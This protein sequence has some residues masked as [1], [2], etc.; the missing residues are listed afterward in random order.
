MNVGP[1][2]VNVLA[3]NELL[4]ERMLQNYSACLCSGPVL[5]ETM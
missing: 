1:L 5:F 2:K 4:W 3:R